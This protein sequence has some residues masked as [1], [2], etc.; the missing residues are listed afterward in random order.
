LIQV[1]PRD[2][3]KYLEFYKRA[4]E[5]YDHAVTVGYHTRDERFEHDYQIAEVRVK[6]LLMRT[7]PCRILDMGCGNGAFP[8]RLSENGF[9]CVGVD[10]DEWVLE[11]SSKK[12]PLVDFRCGELTQLT[13]SEKFGCITLIDSFEHL[14]DPVM[15][16]SQITKLLDMKGVLVL[17]TPD[18]DSDGWKNQGLAWRHMKPIEHPF[19]YNEQNLRTL[20]GLSG[21]TLFDKIYTI[22]DRCTYYFRRDLRD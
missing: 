7:A 20:L 4:G 12:A 2:E 9:Q 22:P 13:F 14:L 17:E 5:Y 3:S 15:Y 18:P 21:L 10:L 16:L 19:I 1:G 6:N 8:C 11:Y